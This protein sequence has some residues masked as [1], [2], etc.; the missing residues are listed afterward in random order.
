MHYT[1]SVFYKKP[2]LTVNSNT[3]VNIGFFYRK[4]KLTN[5]N[6]GFLK[7][8]MLTVNINTFVNIGF[9]VKTDVNFQH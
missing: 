5:V 6:I 3:F 1:Q 4:L 9:F 7:K 2:M 8:P